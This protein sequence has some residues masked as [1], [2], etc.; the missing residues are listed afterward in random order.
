MYNAA[1][2][3]LTQEHAKKMIAICSATKTAALS[4]GRE[5]EVT[6]GIIEG[7]LDPH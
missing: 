5:F 3:A 1:R 6:L 2:T 4:S 7:S